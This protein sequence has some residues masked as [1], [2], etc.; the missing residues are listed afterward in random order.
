LLLWVVY[1]RDSSSFQRPS[2]IIS[3]VPFETLMAVSSS[4]AYTGTGI[5]EAH[6]SAFAADASG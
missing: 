3:T 5:F 4:I 1:R 6:I 2:E